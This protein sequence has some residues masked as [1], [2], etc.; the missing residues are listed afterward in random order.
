VNRASS[1]SIDD[2]LVNSVCAL[3]A[4]CMVRR[5]QYATN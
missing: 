1:D 5:Y 4:A 2:L 3:L